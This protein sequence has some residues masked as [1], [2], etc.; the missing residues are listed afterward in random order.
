MNHMAE[1]A[2]RRVKEGT[3]IAWVQDGLSD[4]WRNEAMV[5]GCH[6]HLHNLL[7][8]MADGR[9]LMRSDSVSLWTIA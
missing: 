3:A 5:C 6:C 2:V 9:Q 1:G 4:Q 7:D 8:T